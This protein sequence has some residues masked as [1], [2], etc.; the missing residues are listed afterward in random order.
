MSRLFERELDVKDAR[1]AM[2][3][4]RRVFCQDESG[5]ILEVSMICKSGE[6]FAGGDLFF[7]V[8]YFVTE[9]A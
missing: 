9:I 1:D 2:M 5:M 3:K 8:R 7:P 6:A 4:G